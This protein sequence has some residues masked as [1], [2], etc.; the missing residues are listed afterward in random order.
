M[1]QAS[2]I[3]GHINNG[4]IAIVNPLQGYFC[5]TRSHKPLPCPALA[6]CPAGSS[7]PVFNLRGVLIFLAAAL[8]YILLFCLGKQLLKRR[9]RRREAR[10]VLRTQVGVIE[11]RTGSAC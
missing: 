4:L 3:I 9:S 10:D 5:P 1:Q 8:T 6:H 11:P 2:L 7:Y